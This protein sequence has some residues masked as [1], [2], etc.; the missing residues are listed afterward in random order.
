MTIRRKLLLISSEF[1]LVQLLSCQALNDLDPTGGN[2]EKGYFEISPGTTLAK[3]AHLTYTIGDYETFSGTAGHINLKDPSSDDTGIAKIASYDEDGL[4]ELRGVGVGK[5]RI[6][7][8]AQ[9][10]GRTISDAFSVQV[11]KVTGLAF[12][13]CSSDGTYVRGDQA[14]IGYVFK[15]RVSK[16]VHGLGFYPF[17][18]SPSKGLTLQKSAST[19]TEFSFFIEDDAPSKISIQSTL[20]GD[21]AEL[22]L[23]IVDQDDFDDVA[24]LSPSSTECGSSI[25]VDLR[26]RV[27]GRPVCS[28]IRRVLRSLNPNACSIDGASDN[29]LETTNLSATVRLD[30]IDLCQLSLEFP[31]AD[32]VFTFESFVVTASQSSGGGSGI[33]WDD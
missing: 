28:N 24:A 1:V 33:S 25:T 31:D 23:A 13:P 22:S 6:S 15:S 21:N 30:A 2:S 19:T 18:T 32:K 10:D 17:E 20:S 26:P 9:A 29:K 14:K 27:N 5:T 7:F 8:T 11:V 3:G 12:L 4:V 16:D